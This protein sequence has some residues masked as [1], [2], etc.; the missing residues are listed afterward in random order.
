MFQGHWYLEHLILGVQRRFR[1]KSQHPDMIPNTLTPLT[2][3][4]VVSEVPPPV[5]STTP[6]E[7]V[8]ERGAAVPSLSSV[9]GRGRQVVKT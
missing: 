9:S 5:R 1:V 4:R 7:S 6:V 8:V 3:Y 2:V